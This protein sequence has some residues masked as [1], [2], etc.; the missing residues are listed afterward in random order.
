MD[1]EL[2]F[3]YDYY[4]C[5]HVFRSILCLSIFAYHIHNAEVIDT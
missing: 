5:F 4:Y 3:L 2:S 1:K